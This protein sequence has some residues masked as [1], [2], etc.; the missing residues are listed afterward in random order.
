MGDAVFARR[1]KRLECGRVW[2]SDTCPWFHLS[3]KTLSQQASPSAAA[4]PFLPR[5]SAFSG[6][7]LTSKLLLLEKSIS[8]IVQRN[9]HHQLHRS[10]VLNNL[11][12][13]NCKKLLLLMPIHVPDPPSSKQ[14]R[15]AKTKKKAKEKS[16]QGEISLPSA[17]IGLIIAVGRIYFLRLEWQSKTQVSW[18]TNSSLIKR[19][20]AR[21]HV[22]PVLPKHGCQLWQQL[23][24][25]A[26]VCLTQQQYKSSQTGATSIL[27]PHEICLH[28][29]FLICFAIFFVLKRL[30]S[31]FFF[32]KVIKIVCSR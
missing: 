8:V 12:L 21:R 4:E 18:N 10:T 20:I 14:N 13:N 5:W 22:E 15:K 31:S 19:T 29:L 9:R 24:F 27:S 23:V 16:L 28:F 17:K 3:A 6:F 7:Q 26:P 11:S 1:G 32:L 25:P 30:P 2:S